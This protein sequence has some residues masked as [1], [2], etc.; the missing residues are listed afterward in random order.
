MSKEKRSKVGRWIAFVVMLLAIGGYGLYTLRLNVS[1]KESRV[2]NNYEPW[3]EN[4]VKVSRD[5]AIQDGGRIKPFATWAGF[6]MLKLHGDRGMTIIVNGKKVKLSPEEV[7]LDCLFRPELARELPV[8]RIDDSN[9]I[10]SLAIGDL[11]DEV[12]R[13][14]G[15][16]DALVHKKVMKEVTKG[17][18]RR[19]RYSFAELEPIVPV[20]LAR[21]QKIRK[22]QPDKAKM[23]ANQR[24]TVDLAETVWLFMQLIYH[25]DFARA[26]VDIK[27]GTP[28]MDKERM[29]RMSY[30]IKSFP[31]LAEAVRKMKPEGER[32]PPQ[33]MALFGDL[34]LRMRRASE[35]IKFVPPYGDDERLWSPMGK[36]MERVIGGDRR[37]AQALVEDIERLEDAHI[38]LREKGQGTFA[39][40][41]GEWKKSVH[42]RMDADQVAKLGSEVK[43]GKWN[44]F[45]KALVVFLIA[46][47]FVMFSWLSP[48]SLGAKICTII[49]GVFAVAALGL[50]IAGIVHRSIIMERSPVGNLYDTI[51]FIGATGVLVLLLTELMTKRMVAL[52]LAVFMGLV[53]MFLARRYEIGDAKDHMDPLVAVLKSNFWLSTHVVTVT[54]GYMGGLA[55]A[56]LSAVYLFARVLGIDEGDKQ[57]RR[58][59]TR[60]A[61]GMICFTLFFSLIGTVLGGIWANDSWGRFWGWDPKENGALMIVLWCLVL[62]HARLAG[63]LREWGLHIAT[64]FGANIVAFSWWHVNSLSTGLHSYGFISGIGVI[65]GFYY[66]MG[67]ICLMGLIAAFVERSSRHS[68]SRAVSPPMGSDQLS[69]DG[70]N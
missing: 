7:L 40:K 10:T 66:L 51:L 20:L 59:M 14:A 17:K 22:D 39:T 15:I 11:P 6:N 9:V 36:R 16:D 4:V 27:E 30:W 70:V 42:E 63:Y 44:Y 62:L 60:I 41:L 1:S 53:C 24:H 46:F 32:M 52:G 45:F 18:N 48:R 65:W 68:K 23:S 31:L 5:M 3:E 54:I 50:M 58:A 57:W 38:A 49:A 47:L 37:H 29:Q 35:D 26:D 43:Y 56:G 12:K 19:D 33:L 61:Y 2:M 34:E 13:A 21:A 55:A 25:M 8:F 67:A 64:V 28:A 69:S